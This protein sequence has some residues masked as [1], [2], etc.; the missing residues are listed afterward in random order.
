MIVF[1]VLY[2][3]ALQKF[4]NIELL[5][6]AYFVFLATLTGN[7]I[8]MLASLFNKEVYNLSVKEIS[9][10]TAISAITLPIVSLLANLK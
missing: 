5:I 6:G 1:P 4:V 9:L 10:T 3:L 7:M 8:A 2:L